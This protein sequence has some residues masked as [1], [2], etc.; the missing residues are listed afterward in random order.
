MHFRYAPEI[1][2]P[3][4]SALPPDVLDWRLSVDEARR[5]GNEILRNCP[6]GTTVRILRREIGPWEEVEA[7]AAA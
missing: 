1:T 5:V 6:D 4:S 3:D 7:N 2:W